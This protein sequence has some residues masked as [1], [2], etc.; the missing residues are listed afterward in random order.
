MAK[1]KVKDDLDMDGLD[2]DLDDD[3][4]DGSAVDD[5]GLDKNSELVEKK[6]LSNTLLAIINRWK[7]ER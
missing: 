7:E 4:L 1:D 5:A 6:V 2:V 3:E